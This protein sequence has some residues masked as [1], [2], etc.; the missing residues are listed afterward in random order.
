LIDCKCA[1]CTGKNIQELIN[2]PIPN[3]FDATKLIFAYLELDALCDNNKREAEI[4]KQ[5]E[6]ILNLINDDLDEV[7]I[8]LE[9][10]SL[11]AEDDSRKRDKEWELYVL[12]TKRR[13]DVS[14][15]AGQIRAKYNQDENSRRSI[16]DRT[17]YATPPKENEIE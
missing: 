11:M 12:S 13:N 14:E 7:Q 6:K 8:Q 10:L 4:G 17:D 16:F 5:F 1:S 15:N 3:I 9:I 2:E